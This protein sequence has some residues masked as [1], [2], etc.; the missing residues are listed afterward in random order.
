MT[1]TIYVLGKVEPV[2]TGDVSSIPGKG[3]RVVVE[4]YTHFVESVTWAIKDGALYASILAKL[5]QLPE[6]IPVKLADRL[7]NM[8]RSLTNR[9]KGKMYAGEY[10]KFRESLYPLS[11]NCPLWADLDA[12]YTKLQD[13]S[14]A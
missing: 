3:E 11:T 9:A 7:A 2:F 1:L 12:V 14:R 13:P 6:A 4:D 8:L 5:L 10:P